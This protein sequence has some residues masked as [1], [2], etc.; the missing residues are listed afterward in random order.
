MRLRR[1]LATHAWL[2]S[3]AVL[4]GGCAAHRLHPTHPTA[5][6]VHATTTIRTEEDYTAARAD[7]D[8]MLPGEAGRL[9]KRQRRLLGRS[10]GLSHVEAD[11]TRSVRRARVAATKSI[12]ASSIQSTRDVSSG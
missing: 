7:Y 9:D 2:L 4:A 12:L 10:N 5:V 8:A 3:L 1:R 11:P 6:T